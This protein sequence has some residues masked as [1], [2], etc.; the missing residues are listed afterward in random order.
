MEAVIDLLI[1]EEHGDHLIALGAIIRTEVD[2]IIVSE[3]P[4]VVGIIGITVAIKALIDIV[5]PVSILCLIS[6]VNCFHVI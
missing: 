2:V 1:E 5:R 6:Y 4:V 3:V